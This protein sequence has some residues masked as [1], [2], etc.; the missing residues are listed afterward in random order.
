MATLGW[1]HM[2][3]L[4]HDTIRVLT[5]HEASLEA[6][7]ATEQSKVPVAELVSRNIQ[8]AVLHGF[9]V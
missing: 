2:R 5:V 1:R 8:L 9:H 7:E 3:T 6:G 4:P